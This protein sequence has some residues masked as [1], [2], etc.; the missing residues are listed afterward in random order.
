[1]VRRRPLYMAYHDDEWGRPVTDERDQFE[2]LFLDG[3]QAGLS[4]I[5][6]LRKR[7]GYR[8]AF[9]GFDPA[10]LAGCGDADVDRLLGDAGIVRNRPKV[11]PSSATPGPCWR[12]TRPARRSASWS[13]PSRPPPR[14]PPPDARRRDPRHDPEAEALSKALKLRGF[15]FVGPTIVYAHMQAAGVVDDHLGCF[16]G[17]MSPWACR[18]PGR[19]EQRKA[20][21]LAKLADRGCRR[22]GHGVADGE[23]HLVPL[24]LAWDGDRVILAR[25]AAPAPSPTSSDR[26]GPASPSAPS[27]TWS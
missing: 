9:E 8:R 5:T 27:A 11:Q 4:W 23:A 12:C 16:Q 14:R 19:P 25:S 1:M 15:R 13:G 3:A 18:P 21:S 26:A 24:S 17:R 20:D 6:I 2:L 22:G 10:V 7:D